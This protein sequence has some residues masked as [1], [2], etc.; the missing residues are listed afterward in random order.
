MIRHAIIIE[1]ST[2]AR[3]FTFNTNDAMLFYGHNHHAIIILCSHIVML[4]TYHHLA[5][6]TDTETHHRR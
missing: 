4:S 2:N 5:I 6:S 1:M 3:P